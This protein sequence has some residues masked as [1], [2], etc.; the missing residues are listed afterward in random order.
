MP[1]TYTTSGGDALIIFIVL[2]LILYRFLWFKTKP[3]AHSRPRAQYPENEARLT[4]EFVSKLIRQN[5]AP[6]S[7]LDEHEEKIS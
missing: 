4:D 5:N 7:R 1:P 2:L 3:V 6:V